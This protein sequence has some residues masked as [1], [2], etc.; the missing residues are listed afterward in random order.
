MRKFRPGR[1]AVSL[2]SA[3]RPRGTPFGIPP[4]L[5]KTP[6]RRSVDRFATR[7]RGTPFGN[8]PLSEEESRGKPLN[9]PHTSAS[10]SP[11]FGALRFLLLSF[12]S[13]VAPLVRR[14]F[15]KHA[16]KPK[17][18]RRT[19]PNPPFPPSLLIQSGR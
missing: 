19:K 9:N 15:A 4:C 5:Y 6:F 10:A 14:R 12:R 16:S 2:C 1:A 13:L 18:K 7:P 3:T 17:R 11:R 8:P